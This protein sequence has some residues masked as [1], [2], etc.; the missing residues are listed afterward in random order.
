[1]AF[2]LALRLLTLAASSSSTKSLMMPCRSPLRLARS[3]TSSVL[4]VVRLA[5]RLKLSRSRATF[6]FFY[7]PPVPD[8]QFL[9][10]PVPRSEGRFFKGKKN[11]HTDLCP[12]HLGQCTNELGRG[13]PVPP[14][15]V[16]VDH[17]P[18]GEPEGGFE[19]L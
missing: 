19:L 15:A 14:Q 12:D 6:S 4:T 3:S 1:M 17:F 2:P 11:N 13:V 18:D 16:V 7:W 5:C 10:P 8:T 9:S